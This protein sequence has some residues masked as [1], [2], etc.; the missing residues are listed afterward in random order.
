MSLTFDRTLIVI[1]INNFK[2]EHFLNTASTLINTLPAIKSLK[3]KIKYLGSVQ[4]NY[5]DRHMSWRDFIITFLPAISAVVTPLLYGLKK[6]LYARNYFGP[7]VAYQWAKPWY[8][9]SSVALIPLIGLALIR[10][11]RA[12]RAITLFEK[13]IYIQSTYGRKAI[14]LWKEIAGIRDIKI[15]KT[16]LGF[17]IAEEYRAVISPFSGKPI[18]LDY[19]IKNLEEMCTRVKAKIF[20]NLL[21]NY[22]SQLAEGRYL[23]FGPV[24]FNNHSLS[25]DKIKS[26]WYKVS[27]M[28]IQKGYIVFE[29]GDSP[30]YKIPVE[31]IPNKE[32]FLQLIQ[33]RVEI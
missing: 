19:Q 29:M 15:V 30:G 18:K 13:G 7:A 16:F 3:T 21:R 26:S 14:L 9:L 2:K 11:R 27:K 24:S 12:H 28:E 17:S 10:L 32:L 8:I 1:V 6:E 25:I 31:R 4:A 23:D 33:E 22:R 5:Y 20:P